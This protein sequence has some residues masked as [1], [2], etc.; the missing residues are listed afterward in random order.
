MKSKPVKFGVKVWA[1]ANSES[2]YVFHKTYLLNFVYFFIPV[3]FAI[4]L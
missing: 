2:R 4:M 1:L 3:V